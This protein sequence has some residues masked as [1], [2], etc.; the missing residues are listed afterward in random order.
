MSDKDKRNH[1]RDEDC[2]LNID[3]RRDNWDNER[4]DHHRENIPRECD[5]RHRHTDK[6]HHGNREDQDSLDKSDDIELVKIERVRIDW[7]ERCPFFPEEKR[8]RY[9]QREDEHGLPRSRRTGRKRVRNV[10][11]ERVAIKKFCT[12]ATHFERVS[13]SFA[14][15]SISTANVDQNTTVWRN[16][17]YSCEPNQ[18]RYIYHYRSHGQSSPLLSIH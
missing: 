12:C 1:S 6:H 7:S 3:P 11:R 8:H 2:L 5:S 16:F 17:D 9:K 13:H 18:F 14:T 10:Q 15:R 4:V